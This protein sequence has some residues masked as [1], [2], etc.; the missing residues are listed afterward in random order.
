[1]GP[2]C[3]AISKIK[4]NERFI[5]YFEWFEIMHIAG[6]AKKTNILN[7]YQRRFLGSIG[8]ILKCKL[9]EDRRDIL[10]SEKQNK[11]FNKIL[12]E[13]LDNYP[14]DWDCY[15]ENCSTCEK[16]KNSK[17]ILLS[18]NRSAYCLNEKTD[19]A[20]KDDHLNYINNNEINAREKSNETKAKIIHKNNKYQFVAADLE[21]EAF[22]SFRSD[23]NGEKIIFNKNHHLGKQLAYAFE[24][25]IGK[26]VEI[27]TN[28]NNIYKNV[29]LKIIISWAQ[30]EDGLASTN[31]KTIAES[32]RIDIG[33]IA[34]NI[35]SDPEQ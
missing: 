2:H 20:V 32:H 35:I 18:K 11:Y 9:N 22:V 31:Q 15:I 29:L 23:D 16:L 19:D 27:N 5:Q 24:E 8:N 17:K 1:L 12:F 10:L 34:K 14:M 30:Y 33:L 4:M 26:K 3:Q 13:F 21:S 25:Y 28:E 6:I 7:P